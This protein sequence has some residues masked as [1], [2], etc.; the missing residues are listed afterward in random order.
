MNLDLCPFGA[1]DFTV[2]P[3]G[4]GSQPSSAVFALSAFQILVMSA[5][6]HLVSRYRT[7]YPRSRVQPGRA[8]GAGSEK[9]PRVRPPLDLGGKAPN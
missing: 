6:A 7:A 2:A 3:H 5:S 9:T 8:L 4:I 1:E